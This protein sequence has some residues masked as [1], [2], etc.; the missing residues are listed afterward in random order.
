MI[1]II[2]AFIVASLTVKAAEADGHCQQEDGDYN[3]AQCDRRGFLN[4]AG[5]PSPDTAVTV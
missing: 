2:V 4:L 1:F 3:Q 5:R